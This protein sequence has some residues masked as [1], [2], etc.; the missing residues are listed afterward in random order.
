MKKKE[1]VDPLYPHDPR[2]NVMFLL[3]KMDEGLRRELQDD[4]RASDILSIAETIEWSIRESVN[5][6]VEIA[7]AHEF[8]KENGVE[9]ERS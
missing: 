3:R 5:T 9:I 4:G 1:G 7:I 2:E 6:R 8:Q